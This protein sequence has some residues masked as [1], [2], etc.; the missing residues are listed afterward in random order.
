[1]EDYQHFLDDFDYQIYQLKYDDA[2]MSTLKPQV[3]AT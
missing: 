2:K 1:M 3:Q